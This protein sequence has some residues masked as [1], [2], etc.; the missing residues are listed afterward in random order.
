MLATTTIP[1]VVKAP[2][3]LEESFTPETLYLKKEER[4][5]FQEFKKSLD[6][7]V[8]VQVLNYL[9]T[10][11]KKASKQF[12]KDTGFTRAYFSKV[13]Q[14]IIRAYKNFMWTHDYSN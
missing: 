12:C 4:E 10:Y 3:L 7:E 14:D 11:D 6:K 13:R 2:L 8:M 1:S 5:I 9:E